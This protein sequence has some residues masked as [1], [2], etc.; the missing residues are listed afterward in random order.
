[1][2]ETISSLCL[3]TKYRILLTIIVCNLL[4][5]VCKSSF[6]IKSLHKFKNMKQVFFFAIMLLLI[7]SGCQQFTGSGNIITQDRQTD[8][9][10]GVAA[11]GAFEVEI[12][13]GTSNKV[14]VECDDNL[15]P[16][17]K[18][19]VVNGVLEISTSAMGGFNNAHMKIFVTAPEIDF[20]DASG[21]ATFKANN[22]LKSIDKIKLES[23]GAATIKA[24]V[25]APQIFVKASGA[26]TVELNGRTRQYT[27][28]ASGSADL[29]TTNL[30]S[31]TTDVTANGASS[32]HV[33]AS[34]SLIANASGAANIHYRGAGTVQKKTSGA[35]DIDP[36]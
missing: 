29:K 5:V 30:Q 34:V 26:S 13:N 16:Y 36:E 22:E 7:T 1:M 6:I 11:G 9:F 12:N 19:K 28:K 20:I 31:E 33:H 8:P 3:R 25:D 27:A 4:P 24:A 2:I 15:M 10:K 17:I 18:T 32:A 21:A 14:T 35:A 23:S